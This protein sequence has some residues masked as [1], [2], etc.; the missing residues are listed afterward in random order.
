MSYGKQVQWLDY[1]PSRVL[2]VTLTPSFCAVALEDGS[3]TVY[4]PT[5]RRYVINL[6]ERLAL[7]QDI[8]MMPTMTLSSQCAIFEGSK[9]H[10][11]AITVHGKMH[12]WYV[13]VL[14]L[15]DLRLT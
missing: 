7:I 9:N 13:L 6:T 4:S 5:G 14:P 11:M 10:L 1:L 8:R 15:F 12:I 3:I 2:L